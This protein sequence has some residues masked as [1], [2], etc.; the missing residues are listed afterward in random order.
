MAIYEIAREYLSEIIPTSF[1]TI[2]LTKRD[3]LQ[4]LLRDQ[5]EVI[6]LDTLI[7]SEEF[8]EWDDSKHRI[9]LLH[10]QRR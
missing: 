4:R 5:I 7:I 3:D 6:S 8:G 1:I 9:D 10:R 2:G